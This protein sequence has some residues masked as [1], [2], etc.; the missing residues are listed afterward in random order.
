[1]YQFEIQQLTENKV[2]L[3]RSACRKISRPI[4][5]TPFWWSQKCEH[6]EMTHV[7]IFMYAPDIPTY[8]R[9]LQTTVS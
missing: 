1:M 5:E 7:F 3:A 2:L 6:S 9:Y 4:I 8:N